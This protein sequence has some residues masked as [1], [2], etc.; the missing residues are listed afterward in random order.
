MYDLKN[1]TIE[2]KKD[3]FSFLRISKK[4]LNYIIAKKNSKEVESLS[5]IFLGKRKVFSLVSFQK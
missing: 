1:K 4:F 2:N 3:I 5:Y